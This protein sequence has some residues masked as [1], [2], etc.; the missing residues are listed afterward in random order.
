MALLFSRLRAVASPNR[1]LRRIEI[2]EIFGNKA[3][4]FA[5]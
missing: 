2:N 3:E 4:L 5:V 1:S